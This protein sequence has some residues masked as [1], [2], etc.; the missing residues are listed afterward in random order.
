MILL[1]AGSASP[2]AV[3]ASGG[4][5]GQSSAWASNLW[6]GDATSG[7]GT[8]LADVRT[9]IGANTSTTVNLT[10]AGVG[11]AL[12][13]TGV[14]PVDGLPAAK[15]VNGPDLSFE[16]QASGL[17]YL[18]TYGHGTHMAGIIMGNDPSTGTKGIAPGVKLTSVKVGTSSGA[19]DVSQMIAAI[20]WV[21]AHR[22]DD[23]ANPIRVINL[24]YGTGGN[25]TS[26]T[27][28]VQYAVEQAWLKGIVV[29]AAAGNGGN[30]DLIVAD[31]ANDPYVIS[32]GAGDTKGTTV[33]NDD[34]LA[35]FST[36]GGT[37][38]NVDV[39][40]PGKSIISLADPGSNV[41]VSYPAARV[42]ATL[43]RGSGSSQAAA[44]T[45][46]AVALLLQA[47]P[48]LTPDKVKD[49]L[50]VTG[51]DVSGLAG[52]R[53]IRE[54]N[55]AGALNYTSTYVQTWMKSSGTG[56]LEDARGS[57]HVTHDSASLTGE[58][59]VWGNLNT[60]TWAPK[61]GNQ[62]AWSAGVWMGFRV[63]GDGW[64]GTSWASK[65]WAS[66]TWTGNAWDG[67]AWTDPT[68]TGHYWTGHYWTS[69]AWSGHY[70]TSDDWS[71]AYWG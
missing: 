18:D 3:L 64:T 62:T 32:V 70:W 57:S 7:T 54:I 19:V 40:A 20:D 42:G 45:S 10:G 50:H 24:S 14:A 52:G 38:R 41:D 43:F 6:L 39:L 46:A 47:R 28:P 59:S 53:G 29:V 48:T 61:S 69:G 37:G 5:H 8:T 9:S 16:S 13:D 51:V 36:L 22:N 12:I 26:W 33:A 63:A 71:A 1:G 55:L 17:R 68:W 23:P 30:G 65:T 67:V 58:K 15:V 21:V 2:S 49:V 31:P 25:P 56:K 34:D 11:V 27:D 60:A 35:S 66:A 44:V 4:T